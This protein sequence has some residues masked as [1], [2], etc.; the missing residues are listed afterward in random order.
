MVN[1]KVAKVAK[2]NI[3]KIT[4]DTRCDIIN[5]S[6][7]KMTALSHVGDFGDRK[8]AKLEKKFEC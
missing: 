6:D 4:D 8:V 7:E 5:Q 3:K 1:Q 2:K